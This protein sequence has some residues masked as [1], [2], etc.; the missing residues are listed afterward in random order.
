[1]HAEKIL[2]PCK[3]REVW[4]VATY[5]IYMPV[6]SMTQIESS[7]SSPVHSQCSGPGPRALA[8]IF[9]PES[10]GCGDRGFAVFPSLA[11]LVEFRTEGVFWVAALQSRSC[12]PWTCNAI[13]FRTTHGVNFCKLW[14]IIWWRRRESNPR[15]KSMSEERLHAYSSSEDFARRA[16]NRQDARN[17]SPMI[18]FLRL[19]PRLRNQPAVRRSSATHRR[20]H[21]ER[22]LS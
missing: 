12:H 4:T 17:A 16:Q 11:S 7:T 20:S 8:P 5:K 18:S 1:L 6:Q 13:R 10:S 2:L 3:R 19:G 14:K 21:G 9:T 22:L 15:P